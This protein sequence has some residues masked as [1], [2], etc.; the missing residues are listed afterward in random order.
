MFYYIFPVEIPLKG[1]MQES[2]WRDSF[3]RLAVLR[4]FFFSRKQKDPFFHI[5]MGS[6]WLCVPIWGRYR[7]SLGLG[8][9]KTQTQQPTDIPVNKWTSTAFARHA[10]LKKNAIAI[11]LL[12]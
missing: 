3:S 4:V 12:F 5:L 10:D 1:D 7:F 8:W 9:G 2:T 6:V 11:N